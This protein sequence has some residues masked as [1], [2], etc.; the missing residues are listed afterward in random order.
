[1]TIVDIAFGNSTEVAETWVQPNGDS[2]DYLLRGTR[3][4]ANVTFKNAGTG[5]SS[6]DAIG[7]LEAIHP[8]GFVIETWTFN[9]SLAGG[10]QD[11]K[12]IE[13]IPDAAHSILDDDGT[14]HGGIIFRGSIATTVAGLGDDE[15]NNVY[16]EHIAIALWHDPMEGTFAADTPIW[17]PI[18]YTDRTAGA[19][20]I[21]G[22]GE[23]WQTDNTSSAVG[24]NHWRI[25]PP[26]GG[27]YASNTIDMLKWGWVPTQGNCND[28]GH[29]LGYGSIDSDIEARYGIPF[30]WLNI[31]LIF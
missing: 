29:G 23:D 5:F 25:S 12:I 27:N 20:G 11:V 10:Q 24:S 1:M 17:M 26:G 30:C 13:W 8:I 16:E 22:G 7:T 21:Y 14:L 4:A 3:Y 2:V 9:L 19:S 6:V 31:M 18:S 28:P 15:S